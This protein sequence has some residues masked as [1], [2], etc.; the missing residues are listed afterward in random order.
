MTSALPCP[1]FAAT[2]SKRRE[3]LTYRDRIFLRSAASTMH[4]VSAAQRPCFRRD[5]PQNEG[6]RFAVGVRLG[7]RSFG[8]GLFALRLERRARDRIDRSGLDLL[9]P[10]TGHEVP[11]AELA[12]L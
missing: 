3:W 12:K 1:R 2:S 4:R 6:Y 8:R 9:C 7:R 10:V 5:S 11:V